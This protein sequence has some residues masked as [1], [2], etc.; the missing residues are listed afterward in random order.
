MTMPRIAGASLSSVALRRRAAG[1]QRHQTNSRFRSKNRRARLPLSRFSHRG[2]TFE[3]R[4]SVAMMCRRR[5]S[6]HMKQGCDQMQFMTHEQCER[7]LRDRQRALPQRQAGVNVERFSYP[8]K[9]GRLRFVAHW[10]ATSIGYR[11]PILLWMTEWGIWP[12]SENWH[13]YYKLRQSQGDHRLLQDAPGHLFLDFESED[14]ASYLQLAMLNGWG[15]YLLTEANYVNAFFSHD[16]YIDFFAEKESE[17]EAVR[18]AV[19]SSK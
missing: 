6:T 18:N 10:I 12:S 11:M 5:S 19:G 1:A 17:L 3:A 15:G 8:P 13:L 2:V 9:P 14:L 16:E 7:W 4:A